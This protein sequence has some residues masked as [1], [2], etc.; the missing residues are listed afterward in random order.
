MV[1]VI[2]WRREKEPHAG[3]A[4][5]RGLGMNNPPFIFLHPED[6]G[7]TVVLR[8]SVASSSTRWHYNHDDL[9]DESFRQAH[10]AFQLHGLASHDMYKTDRARYRQLP[11]DDQG[12]TFGGQ[13]E[14]DK[15]FGLNLA[16]HLQPSGDCRYEAFLFLDPEEDDPHTAVMDATVKTVALGFA[17]S[18]ARI[19]GAR[20]VA[21]V[22]EIHN[23]TGQISRTRSRSKPQFLP[24]QQTR[25][26]TKRDTVIIPAG[27]EV[28]IGIAS[29]GIGFTVGNG[30]AAFLS[31]SNINFQIS[32]GAGNLGNPASFSAGNSKGAAWDE[33]PGWDDDQ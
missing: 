21:A 18:S 24:R 7:I 11:P 10:I 16:T 14:A 5:L 13:E 6:R 32:G 19:G 33:F 23:H 27:D 31:E 30:G 8:P 26:S 15:V 4:E 20:S 3:S 12:P 2:E 28:K 25:T 17:T 29:V 1:Y 9:G 22:A